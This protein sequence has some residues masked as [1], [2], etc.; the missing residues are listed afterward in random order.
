MH[1]NTVNVR[2]LVNQYQTN[3][4]RISEI[5]D[6][7][8]REQRE[9]NE[10]ENTEFNALQRENQLLQMRLQAAAAEHL[11]ENPNAVEDAN[12]II[13]ENMAAGRQTQIMLMRDLVMVADGAAG[14]IVPVKIQ[15]I[16]DPLVEGLILDKVGLPMPTGLA[17]DYVWP[18][19]ETV[20]STVAGEGVALTDTKIKMSKLTA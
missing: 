20:E 12:R 8:E 17:G 5:A 14:G 2:Q 18:T 4:N 3:C 7:C 1:K 13:R 9:R 15:D 6:T 11:R 10:A 19:Y 16:L